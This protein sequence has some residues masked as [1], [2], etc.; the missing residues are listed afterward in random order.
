MLDFIVF[1][2]ERVSTP[3]TLEAESNMDGFQA[4]LKV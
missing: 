1:V 2:K 3:T 4:W